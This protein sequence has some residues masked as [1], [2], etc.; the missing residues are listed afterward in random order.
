VISWPLAIDVVSNPAIMGAMSNP[1]RVALRPF[2]T[3]R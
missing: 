2:A 3:W 1:D